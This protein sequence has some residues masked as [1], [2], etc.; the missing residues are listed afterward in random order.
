MRFLRRGAW[1]SNPIIR[2]GEEGEFFTP[3]QL[4][5]RTIDSLKDYL[6]RRIGGYTVAIK[7]TLTTNPLYRGRVCGELPGTIDDVSY[8]KP[9]KVRKLGRANRIGTPMFYCCAG[10]FPVFFE[11]HAKEGDLIALSQWMLT[12]S[13]WMHNLGYHPD[14]LD[15]MGAPIL[16]QRSPLVNPIPHETNRNSRLRR[17]MSL[18]FTK[19]VPD[20]QEYRYKET[21]AINELLFDRASPIPNHGQ[22]A[23]KN[24]RVAGTVYPTVRMRG[25]ADN[26]AIWP[27]FVDRYLRIKS[28]RYVRVEAADHQKLA[29]TLL[30]VAHSHTLSGNA[31]D[32]DS[33][34][35]PEAERRT[36]V[37]F[38]D[39]R[40]LFSDGVGRIYDVH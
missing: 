22:D 17:R 13:L 11:V 15:K 31:I 24:S 10:A 18:A 36:Q 37:K 20:G 33:E 39:G 27:E 40:W 9:E 30:T 14:S 1:A 8:P 25:L 3:E 4:E 7:N 12:E 26:I 28:V 6:R 23:P 32:W 38:E 29:Y 35:P 16:P 34:L 2:P 19:D 21:I 5:K